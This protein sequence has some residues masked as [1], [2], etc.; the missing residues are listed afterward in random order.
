[1]K[2]LLFLALLLG[3]AV[4][5]AQPYPSR[6]VRLVVGFPPGGSTD[7]AARALA[8]KLSQS[9]GQPVVVENKPGASGNIAA[10]QMARTAPD[11]Y[12]LLLA[13]TSFASAPAFSAKL[14]WDPVR[15]FT[16]IGL[17]GTVPIVAVT[18]AAVAA[19][20]PQELI[21][22]SRA[23][24]GKMNLASPGAQ[25]L[26]RLSG[27]MF[28][29]AAGLDWVTVHYKGGALAMQD[30]LSGNVQVMFASI[31]EVLGHMKAGR[32][33][34]IA[35][36]T[37]RRSALLPELPTFAESGYP[38]FTMAAWQAVVGPAGMQKETVELLNQHIVRVMS[39]PEMKERFL[40][41]GTD[42][43]TSS[44]AELGKFIAD[45]VAKIRRIAESVGEKAN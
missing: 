4:V 2:K 23:N 11:G 9:L 32:L 33:H 29:Q 34:G 10:E 45:E 16:P 25:T 18:S 26:T 39:A 44:P 3:V 42:A 22:Y 15:D 24:P 8:E 31:S 1:M 28:K 13:A 27:E 6:P 36:T 35:V 43:A 37:A 17:V 19:R 20:T 41:M 40:A 21:A 38:T 30:L 7:L 14:G 12:T 5:Q